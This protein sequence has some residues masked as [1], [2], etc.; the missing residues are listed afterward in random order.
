MLKKVF[1]LELF[2]KT[3]KTFDL[4]TNENYAS[5]ETGIKAFNKYVSE[6]YLENY[7]VEKLETREDFIWRIKSD[8]YL[9]IL[10]KDYA[11]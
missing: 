7:E 6:F 9:L 2:K 4:F 3:N 8:K 11:I 5:R 1:K 10:R